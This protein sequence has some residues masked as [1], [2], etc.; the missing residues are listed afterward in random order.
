MVCQDIPL[1]LSL[2][3]LYSMLELLEHVSEQ[4]TLEAAATS[5][6]K[7]DRFQAK[8]KAYAEV[9]KHCEILKPSKFSLTL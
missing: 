4:K 7:S 3:L 2:L 1:I 6:W 9:G 5:E 8:R